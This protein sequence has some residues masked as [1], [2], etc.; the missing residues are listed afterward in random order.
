[1]IATRRQLKLGNH[2]SQEEEVADVHES[3]Y[4]AAASSRRLYLM[5]VPTNQIKKEEG[6]GRLA[7]NESGIFVCKLKDAQVRVGRV[8]GVGQVDDRQAVRESSRDDG[9]IHLVHQIVEFDYSA[10]WPR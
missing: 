5:S 1:M 7:W 10:V 4:D 3:C 8:E 6:G 9:C 2:T